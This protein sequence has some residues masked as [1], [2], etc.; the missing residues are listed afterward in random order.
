[1]EHGRAVLEQLRAQEGIDAVIVDLHMPDMD[2]L[3]TARAVR[4][5]GESWAAIP[6][7]ALTARS[8]EPAV[9]AA[10]AAGMNAFLV[11]PVDP[12]L[13]YETLARLVTGTPGG[14]QAGGR[15]A[16]LELPGLV[17]GLLNQQRLESYRRL[18]ML[19]ELLHDYVPEMARLVR[20]LQA[21]VES[22][23]ADGSRDALHSLLGMSGEAGAMALY[24]HVRQLYVPL[25]EDGQ[26]PSGT[27]WLGELLDL[28]GRTEEALRAY[29]ETE[30]G[31][32]RS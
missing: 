9:T 10:T 32:T 17:D 14:R 19:D 13:L 29:C 18:G 23:D 6:L 21:A 28:A 1:V 24:Q 25:L 31:S 2:G 8:D 5:S 7:V 4:A 30:S 12:P 26:W 3:D 15:A 20:K 11:K 22:G 16:A 27:A